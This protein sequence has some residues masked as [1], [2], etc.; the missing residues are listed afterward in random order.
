MKFSFYLAALFAAL[1]ASSCRAQETALVN[2]PELPG[3]HLPAMA[4]ELSVPGGGSVMTAAA[5]PMAVAPLP[6]VRSRAVG[7][8]WTDWGLIS[9]ASTL[10]VLDYTTTETCMKHPQI[11]Q[12]EILPNALVH[13]KPGFAAFEGSTVVANYFAYR[14]LARHHRSAVRAGQAVY[15]GLM[16][17]AISINY[18]GIEKYLH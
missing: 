10:R 12:E 1:M 15:D 11:F 2:A 13:N 6:A 5:A 3:P 17:T 8:S 18:Y 9:V 16:G 7:L 4:P 14:S